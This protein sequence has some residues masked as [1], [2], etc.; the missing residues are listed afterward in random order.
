MPM[1]ESLRQIVHEYCKRDL[2]GDL[3]WHINEFSF[4]SDAELKKRLGR[5][6]YSARYVGKLMEALLATGDEIHAFVKFQIMQYASIYEAVISYLLRHQYKDEPAVARMQTHKTYK[7]VSALGKDT[8]LMFGTDE[9]HT[10]IYTDA[11]T[12][13][14]D[15]PFSQKVACAVE[16]GLVREEFVS[17]ITRIYE[18]RN[19]AH[20]EN[21]AEKQIDVELE[22][23]RTA[24]WRMKPFLAC[25]RVEIAAHNTRNV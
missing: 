11:R 20:I 18:L 13:L 22:Q 15:I 19:L 1:D 17:D 12:R 10:C 5:A 4:I 6:Y 7:K 25:L 16:I 14:N 24:Y 23:A 9:L 2:P 3:D 21:E 8:K